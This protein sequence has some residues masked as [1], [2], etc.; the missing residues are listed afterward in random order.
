MSEFYAA[1]GAVIENEKEEILMV[2]EAKDHIKGKWNFPG[3]GWEDGESI[4]ECVKR[5]VLEETGYKVGLTGFLGIYKELNQ[6][7]GTE[8]IVFMFTGKS[9]DKKTDNLEDDIIR[10]KWIS[11]EEIKKLDLR[12]ENRKKIVS[13]YRE[14]EAKDLELLWENLEI[15]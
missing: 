9:E 13:E 4:L 15:L 8:T 10:R 6:D 12:H 14:R 11:L 5:E 1:A 7:D 2:Q 3:G